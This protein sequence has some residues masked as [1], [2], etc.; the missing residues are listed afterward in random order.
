MA[1]VVGTGIVDPD[2]GQVRGAAV[3][4]IQGGKK[5]SRR[6]LL[7]AHPS[8]GPRASPATLLASASPPVKT[9]VPDCP[10]HISGDDIASQLSRHRTNP[11][12]PRRLPSSGVRILTGR[13]RRKVEAIS[14]YS[15]EFREKV[16]GLA[17][18]TRSI[19]FE[20]LPRRW[21]AER[22]FTLG[23]ARSRRRADPVL[24]WHHP[25]AA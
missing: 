23:S 9:S 14:K 6:D 3:N 8:A 15:P 4:A 19:A 21:V 7:A 1:Q 17:G 20:D 2:A 25:T 5:L 11:G 16:A 13:H 24:V 10:R 18:T 22:T 12:N